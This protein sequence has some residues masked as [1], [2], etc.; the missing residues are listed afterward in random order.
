MNNSTHCNANERPAPCNYDQKM[1]DQKFTGLLNDYQN[2]KVIALNYHELVNA[3][4]CVI[5]VAYPEYNGTHIR[6]INP[7]EDWIPTNYTQRCPVFKCVDKSQQT[8]CAVSHIDLSTGNITV[9]LANV[10]NTTSYCKVES[11][12]DDHSKGTCTQRNKIPVLPPLRY[13]GEECNKDSDCWAYVP[14]DGKTGKCVN[15]LCQGLKSENCVQTAQCPVGKYCNSTSKQC[16]N[17]I[18]ENNACTSTIQCQNHLVCYNN[19]CTRTYS[20]PIGTR[21][22]QPLDFD[23]PKVCQFGNVNDNICVSLNSTDPETV[24]K[25]GLTE[26]YYGQSCNYTYS[27][28]DSPLTTLPCECGYNKDGI[29]YC[30]KGQ[31]KGKIIYFIY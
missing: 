20:L 19:N 25:E 2:S 6:P 11:F 31:N 23:A 24:A 3:D 12:F 13:P 10:C 1:K 30:R 29:G 14:N 27:H 21:L 5:N 22:T 15:G 8:D 18:S 26:C 4:D 9:E 16:E 7:S 28:G 17:Q